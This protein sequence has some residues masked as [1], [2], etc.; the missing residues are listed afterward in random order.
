MYNSVDN[1]DNLFYEIT[2][3]VVKKKYLGFF[4]FWIFMQEKV[5]KNAKI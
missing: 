3:V 1:V 2:T 5:S 4:S